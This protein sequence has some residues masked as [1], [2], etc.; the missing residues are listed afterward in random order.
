MLIFVSGH[1]LILGMQMLYF[2]D[3]ELARRPAI[4]PPASVFEG[5]GK[6]GGCALGSHLMAEAGYDPIEMAHLVQKLEGTGGARAPQFLSDHPN[7]GNRIQN[8][9]SE[10]RL[11]P[12]RGYGYQTGAF[13]R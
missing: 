8:I 2:A 13:G 5:C 11:L 1:L 9:E 10:M 6:R 7:P 4:A 12:K 3:P